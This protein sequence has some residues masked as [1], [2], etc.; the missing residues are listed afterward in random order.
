MTGLAVPEEG[1]DFPGIGLFD[2]RAERGIGQHL[3][4]IGKR[5]GPQIH[6]GGPIRK[7]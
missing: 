3:F 6:G 4:P 5:N 2:L 7:T 1:P